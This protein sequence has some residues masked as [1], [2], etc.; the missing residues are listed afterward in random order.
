M[1]SRYVKP[2]PQKLNED[3][4]IGI[5]F[6]YGKPEMDE[7]SKSP[8]RISLKGTTHLT[9]AASSTSMTVEEPSTML[10]T[11]TTTTKPP[12]TTTKLTTA[13]K[14]PF[15]ITNPMHHDT[16]KILSTTT[17]YTNTLLPKK[18]G[19]PSDASSQK[20]PLTFLK[21]KTNNGK[22]IFSPN[23]FEFGWKDLIGV[24]ESV[25]VRR[26]PIFEPKTALNSR[27]SPT[28]ICIFSTCQF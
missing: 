9:M 18:I 23:E 7:T 27:I 19:S 1:Y 24:F 12:A 13:K 14:L 21:R 10:T 22:A 4:I 6:L 3:D 5:Q 17:P 25:I 16:T 8:S 15:V 20:T 28:I 26:K 2:L 11:T